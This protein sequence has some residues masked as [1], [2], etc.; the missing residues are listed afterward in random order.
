MSKPGGL[1]NCFILLVA[2]ATL[3]GVGWFLG[4]AI[5]GFEAGSEKIK[6]V[7]VPSPPPFPPMHPPPPPLPPL[8]P[9]PSP[10]PPSPPPTELS[11]RRTEE[12][13]GGTVEELTNQ[14]M[15]NYEAVSLRIARR[16]RARRLAQKHAHA[17]RSTH[18]ESDEEEQAR[19]RDMIRAS[20]RADVLAEAARAAERGAAAAA[21]PR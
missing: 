21:A 9:P 12:V 8:E 7:A 16:E 6:D 3:I 11:G 10:P 20:V 2:A 4:L 13:A 19:T 17:P 18:D 1:A 15:A 14:R 5:N